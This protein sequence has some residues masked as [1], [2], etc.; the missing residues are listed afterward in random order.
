MMVVMFNY[1]YFAFHCN[2]IQN[3]NTEFMDTTYQN[4]FLRTKENER[5]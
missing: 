1:L 4:W 2:S 5:K 3:V